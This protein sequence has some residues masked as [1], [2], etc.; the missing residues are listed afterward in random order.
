MD[1][2]VAVEVHSGEL[3]R[4]RYP[5]AVGPEVHRAVV[6]DDQD[7]GTVFRIHRDDILH[8]RAGREDGCEREGGDGREYT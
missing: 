5:S 8:C 4:P 1:M 6:L 2:M 7:E 3:F